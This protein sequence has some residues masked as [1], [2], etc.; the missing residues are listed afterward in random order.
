MTDEELLERTKTARKAA[1]GAPR[2]PFRLDMSGRKC[3]IRI[4][5][6]DDAKRRF[7]KR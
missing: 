5:T 6:M 3:V 7:L 1:H 4:V 2:N